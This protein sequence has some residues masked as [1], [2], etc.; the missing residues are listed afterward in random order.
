MTE[1]VDM[2]TRHPSYLALD[3]YALGAVALEVEQHLS[4]C[5]RCRGY[6]DEVRQPA[7]V[8][9]WVTDMSKTRIPLPRMAFVTVP[10]IAVAIAMIVSITRWAEWGEPAQSTR[11][12]Y[13]AAKSAPL[14]VIFLK[15]GEEIIAW[16]HE[17]VRAGD[18]LRLGVSSGGFDRVTVLAEA[19]GAW[20]QLHEGSISESKGPGL[21]MTLL[22]VSF[23]VDSLGDHERLTVVLSHG[24][25]PRGFEPL[26]DGPSVN[27]G[28]KDG[29]IWAQ[30]IDLPKEPI[31][32]QGDGENDER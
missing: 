30:T 18:S 8:P 32:A 17:R 20:I 5:A 26:G 19:H 11:T 22:P 13:V 21:P 6:V 15:R 14:V 31:D 3:R 16:S 24:L 28:I 10:A 7:R 9:D 12:T 1:S 4:A 29:S 25:L 2:R 23:R 27:P